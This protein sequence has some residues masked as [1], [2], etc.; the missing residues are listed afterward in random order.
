[1]SSRNNPKRN[2]KKGI[3]KRRTNSVG[4]SSRHPE[5]TVSTSDLSVKTS[6]AR[7]DLENKAF[8]DEGIQMVRK[9]LSTLNLET[10]GL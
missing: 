6:M 2:S 8:E 7:E 4:G 1:L 5:V 3:A 10:S 9:A